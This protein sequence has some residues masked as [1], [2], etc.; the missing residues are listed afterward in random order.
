MRTEEEPPPLWR[1]VVGDTEPWRRG[2][3]ALRA[4]G[5]LTLLF[6]LYIF[7][8]LIRGGF[9]EFLLANAVQ[10]AFF[11]LQF[12]FIWIGVSWVRWLNG[13]LSMVYGLS[14]FIWGVEIGSGPLL[15]IGLFIIIL[16]AYI[17]FAPAVHFFARHQRENRDRRE[18]LAVAAIFILLLVT[19]GAGLATFAAYRTELQEQAREFADSAF[20]RVFE[21]H[22]TYFFCDHAT[23]RL[24]SPPYGRFYLTRFLQQATVEAGDI[25]ALE[26]CSGNVFLHYGFPATFYVEGEM[27]TNAIGQYGR[28]VLRLTVR[29]VPGSW[30]IDGGR[31]D[32]AKV[33]AYSARR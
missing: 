6:Q 33:D 13:A 2:R 10:T 5:I 1:S 8:F 25:R 4:A 16:G 11:W 32:Y 7:A 14:T 31:W 28:V 27:R 24:L 30:Q 26:P 15:L 3:A 20:S 29:G 18:M 23:R 19:L 17:G 21:E 9:V 22:D 12:Y